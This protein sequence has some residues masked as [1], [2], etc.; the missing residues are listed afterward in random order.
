MTMKPNTKKAYTSHQYRDKLSSD[1]E[2]AGPADVI[3]LGDSLEVLRGFPRG[4]QHDLGYALYRVQLGQTPPD[5]KPMRTV[6]SGVFE[7]REQDERAWYR[8]IY[9]KKIEDVVYVLHCFEKQTA[10]TEQQD[11]NTA[12]ERLK[13]LHKLQQ[14]DKRIAK[15]KRQTSKPPDERERS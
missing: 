10:K 14:Q 1:A 12:R 2:T 4:P 15:Q 3:W 9:L 6:G 7:L 11:I 8:V 13:R 5:S